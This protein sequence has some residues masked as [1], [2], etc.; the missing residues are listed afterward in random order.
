MK[1]LFAE[2]AGRDLDDLLDY[3]ETSAGAEV[4]DEMCDRLERAVGS[5]AA[6]A[7]RGN[8]PPELERIGVYAYRELHCQPYRIIYE[9]TSEAVYVH[10][11]LDARR[12]VQEELAH[13]Q[14]R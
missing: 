6:L 14:L 13:R 1:I 11:I 2:Q 5:L 7:K 9:P 10:A 4:A 3:L 12:N 8:Y